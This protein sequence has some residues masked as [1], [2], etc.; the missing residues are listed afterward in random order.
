MTSARKP[1]EDPC[2]GAGGAEGKM[3]GKALASEAPHRANAATCLP[4]RGQST[5]AKLTSAVPSPCGRRRGHETHF[6]EEDI[7]VQ[8]GEANLLKA[9]RLL[10]R[11][12]EFPT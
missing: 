6:T 10:R 1:R 5:S 3:G 11:G 8:N 12:L 4:L 2:A 9:T 7:K